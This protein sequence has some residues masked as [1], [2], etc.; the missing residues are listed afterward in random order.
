M[1]K[2]SRRPARSG[3]KRRTT[4]VGW[5]LIATACALL[6]GG[7]G[8][9]LFLGTQLRPHTPAPP[10]VVHV[11][12]QAVPTTREPTHPV[13]HGLAAAPVAPPE[14]NPEA[15]EEAAPPATPATPSPGAGKKPEP[16]GRNQLAM[17]FPFPKPPPPFEGTPPWIV[18]AVA[19]PPTLG[20]PVIAV[21]IDDMG[22]DRRRSA[23]AIELPGA[24]TLSFLPYA[25][26]LPAQ[27]RLA[28]SRGHELLVHVPMEPLGSGNNPGP[29][30]LTVGLSGD[31]IT[32][33]LHRDLARFDGFVGINNHMGS[34][35]TKFGPGMATVMAELRARGLLWF[36]SRT[37]GNSVGAA[38]AR[39]YDVP[40]VERDV[41]LD[42]NPALA[43]VQHQLAELEAVARRRGAAVAI[44]HPK[45]HTLD[46]LSAWLPTLPERGFVLV[47]LT[48]IVRGA[49]PN[50]G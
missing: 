10:R 46:A 36:D 34:K 1:T 33:R 14:T 18:N 24:V 21:V 25:E 2:Q 47:P 48:H 29:D 7:L 32:A 35:F 26:E 3:R 44:G 49:Q 39:E 13:E 8:I 11:P 28:H 6:L 30:A 37:T 20:H 19:A 9:G 23:R 22:L 43:A 5:R 17:S 45:D 16:A 15:V 4:R 50:A 41:F 40:H 42:D 12:V 38:V 27:T 31:E